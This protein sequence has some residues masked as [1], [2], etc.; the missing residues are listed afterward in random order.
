[1]TLDDFS[2]LIAFVTTGAPPAYSGSVRSSRR[3][4]YAARTSRD[5][6]GTVLREAD[7]GTGVDTIRPV[8]KVDPVGSLKLSADFVGSIRKEGSGSNPGSPTMHRRANSEM[9]KAG[10]SLVE[11][12]ILPILDRVSIGA[13]V[14]R[15][16]SIF[17]I[18]IIF[19]ANP[20][21]HGR[22]RD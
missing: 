13:S 20:R 18:L 17:N 15:C 14:I 22:P 12:V 8:K 10:T 16:Q 11:D 2:P 21:R 4:S 5:G 7:L 3:A 1:M 9:G 19:P 6:T